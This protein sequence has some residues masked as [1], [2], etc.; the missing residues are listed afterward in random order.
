MLW[1]GS[2]TYWSRATV[3]TSPP[4]SFGNSIQQK[5]TVYLCTTNFWSN[6]I[7]ILRNVVW[8]PNIHSQPFERKHGCYWLLKVEDE[9]RV[10]VIRFMQS[11]TFVGMSTGFVNI[12]INYRSQQLNYVRVVHLSWICLA[13]KALWHVYFHTFGYLFFLLLARR[14]H[15]QIRMHQYTLKNGHGF[16]RLEGW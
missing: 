2:S 14:Q 12:N 15:H 5:V 8:E 4:P 16:F 9:W 11:N 10:Y 7:T 6:V 1:K 3:R 13:Q